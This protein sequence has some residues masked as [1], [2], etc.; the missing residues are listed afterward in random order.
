MIFLSVSSITIVLPTPFISGTLR[1]IYVLLA[2]SN[3]VESLVKVKA[4]SVI[5]AVP[6]SIVLLKI[7]ASIV[8]VLPAELSVMFEA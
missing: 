3:E 1:L 2:V 7:G 4:P 6:M 8:R 5:C